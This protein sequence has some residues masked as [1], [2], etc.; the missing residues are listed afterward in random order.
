MNVRKILSLHLVSMWVIATPSIVRCADTLW[1][2]YFVQS[3]Q[4]KADG[5]YAEAESSLRK[6]IKEAEKFGEKDARLGR[7]LEALGLVLQDQ[8]KYAEAE[9]LLKRS[10]ALTS[11]IE[12]PE[13][14][15][16]AISMNNLGTLYRDLA[17]YPEAENLYRQSLPILQ[18][19]YGNDDVHIA[20]R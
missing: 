18:K 4:C 2:T 6:A 7:T 12:G 11:E 5:H 9:L 16:V 15:N 1:D 13:N 19:S 3:L 20:Q 8:A 14:A 10:N 17:K